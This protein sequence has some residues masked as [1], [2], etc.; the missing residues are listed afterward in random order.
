MLEMGKTQGIVSGNPDGTLNP[1]RNASRV[2]VAT[3]LT[4]YIK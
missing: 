2:E 4:R 1:Q 3:I